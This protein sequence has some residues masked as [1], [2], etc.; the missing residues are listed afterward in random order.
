MSNYVI[1]DIHGAR[2]ALVQCL[3][4]SGFD[5]EKDSLICLGDVCDRGPEV[6][7]AIDALLSIKNLIYILGNHDHW[8]REWAQ[9]GKIPEVWIMQGGHRTVNAYQGKGMPENHRGLFE[10]A[11]HF[12]LADNTLFVHGGINPGLPLDAQDEQTFL[13]DRQLARQA[14][15][16]RSSGTERPLT[17]FETIYVGHTPTLK[18]GSDQPIKACELWLMDTGAGWGGRLSMMNAETGKLVQSDPVADL[19]DGSWGN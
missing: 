11:Q 16:L 6:P 10:N 17:G 19:Y 12:H 2:R 18:Y 5:N 1:G 9:S 8:A 14:I 3:E 13:W 15:E 4:R 7:E